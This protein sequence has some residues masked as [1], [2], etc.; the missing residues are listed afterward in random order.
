MS[1]IALAVASP[2]D[3]AIDGSQIADNAN[4]VKER[5]RR[6]HTTVLLET[7]VNEIFMCLLTKKAGNLWTPIVTYPF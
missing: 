2:S 4:A 5:A 7:L 1:K 6:K 3:C